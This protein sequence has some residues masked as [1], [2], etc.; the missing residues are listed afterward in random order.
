LTEVPREVA[1]RIAARGGR[2]GE[3]SVAARACGSPPG[4]CLVLEGG[5]D[6]DNSRDFRE[7]A[8][9]ALDGT[10]GGEAL[11]L[12]LAGLEYVSST[13]VGTLTT[14]LAEARRRETFLF[15]RGMQVKVK[16]VF[17]VL[18]FSSFFSFLEE[19]AQSAR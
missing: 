5:L 12:D 14:L 13:G 17:D 6:N 11:I 3:L 16:A 2:I 1:E 15:L 4:L 8:Q 10:G 9:A 7:L 19:G 18:G